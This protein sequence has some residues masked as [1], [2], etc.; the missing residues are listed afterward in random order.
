ME[1]SK[2]FVSTVLSTLKQNICNTGDPLG[3]KGVYWTKWSEGLNLPRG[4]ETV[5]L[6]GRM[7]Q[8]L[9][10]IIQVVDLVAMGKPFLSR[11]GFGPLVDLGNALVGTP[12]G[13]RRS[14]AEV[15]YSKGASRNR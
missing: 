5:L 13:A 11:G 2:Q 4:G 14:G 10:Y 3:M 9:P 7:Y 12:Q 1:R 6:T 15:R 8:M